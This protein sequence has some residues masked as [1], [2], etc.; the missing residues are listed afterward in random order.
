MQNLIIRAAS[1]FLYVVVIVFSIL[2]HN[3]WFFHIVFLLFLNMVAVEALSLKNKLNLS[4]IIAATVLLSVIY[5]V[6]VFD[7]HNYL[8]VNTY[9]YGLV[10]AVLFI[11]FIIC[12]KT[13][14]WLYVFLI[15]LYAVFPFILF[16]KMYQYNNSKHVLLMLFVI[17]WSNDTFAYLI[18]K[19]IGKYKI[20]PKISPK[21]TW[22]GFWGGIFITE[23]ILNIALYYFDLFSINS[24]LFIF[25]ICLTGNLGDLFESYLKRIF[26]KKDSGN[27]LPGH[28]GML[29]RLD[30]FLF[31]VPFAFSFL[32]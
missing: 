29:D 26:A 28:G 21:K 12:N 32:G 22:E 1:G 8:N 27:L 5:L 18:G 3:Q 13:K 14:S 31:V 6:F 10:L 16:G 24:I 20:F 23:I 30:S 19:S 2:C 7:F 4:K 15:V 11:V 17:I 25:I 9:F